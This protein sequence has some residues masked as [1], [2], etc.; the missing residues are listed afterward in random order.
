MADLHSED[1]RLRRMVDS[2]RKSRE[3]IGRFTRECGRLLSHSQLEIL[4]NHMNV[5]LKAGG[6][7]QDFFRL[8]GDPVTNRVIL[9]VANSNKIRVLLGEVIV[10]KKKF[11]DH[12]LRLRGSGSGPQK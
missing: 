7:V 5:L 10:E 8:T 4:F 2:S 11:I 12:A 9:K 1:K 6:T 3:A